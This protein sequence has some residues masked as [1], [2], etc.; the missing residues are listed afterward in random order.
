MLTWAVAWMVVR[1]K[2]SDN[3]SEVILV[4]LVLGLAAILADGMI[5]YSLAEIFLNR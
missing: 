3:S 2:D 5:L 1:C 4:S